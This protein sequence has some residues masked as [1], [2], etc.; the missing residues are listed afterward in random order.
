MLSQTSLA[1]EFGR[2]CGL[3]TFTKVRNVKP[4][5]VPGGFRLLFLSWLLH[6]R[7]SNNVIHDLAERRHIQVFFVEEGNCTGL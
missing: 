2:A 3:P 5:S 7:R 6:A 4:P 1:Q